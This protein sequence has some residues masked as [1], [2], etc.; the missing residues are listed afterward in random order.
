MKRFVSLALQLSILGLLTGCQYVSYFKT[1]TT[2][3]PRNLQTSPEAVCSAM[4]AYENYASMD[5]CVRRE[6]LARGHNEF[7]F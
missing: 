5:W 1:N 6:E 4:G 7:G 2:S 3:A